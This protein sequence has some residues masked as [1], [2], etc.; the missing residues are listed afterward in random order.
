MRR[1]ASDRAA[2]R[3]ARARTSANSRVRLRPSRSRS[4]GVS[5]RP[6]VFCRSASACWNSTSL[7]SKPR[8]IH[9]YSSCMAPDVA[10]LR[11]RL[12]NSLRF[13]PGPIA[14][15]V[16]AHSQDAE[17][18]AGGLYR[19]EPSAWAA[20]PD[21]QKAVSNR[22]GWM[23][24]PQMVATEVPRLRA[25]ADAVKRDG[26]TD[27][28][29]LGMGG[30][31]LAPEVL[32][33][34][35]GVAAGWP[36]FHMLDSTDPA[37]V[38]AVATPPATSLYVLA[39]KSGTTIEP[40]ALAAHF[41]QTLVAAGVAEW[42]RHFVAITDPGTE[43]ER[44]A[45]ADGF[46]DVF[47]NPPDIG[48]RYSALSF[49][50]MVPAA[51]MGQDVE[52]IVHWGLAMLAAA[53]PGYGEAAGNPAVALGLALG[54]GAKA[55]RDKMTLVAPPQFEP[56][57]LWVEQLIAESTGKHG[58]G[59]VPIAGESIAQADSYDHDRL[60]VRLRSGRSTT[61]DLTATGAPVVEIDVGEPAALG[62]E[63]V[64]WEIATAVAGALLR[65]NPFDEPNVQ[66]AK[67]ATRRLLEA[68][69]KDRRLPAPPADATLP[70]GTVLTL[71]DAARQAAV[72]P[73]AL[74]KTL[75]SGDYFA[76]LAYV[77]SE[78]EAL[79]RELQALRRAIRDRAHAATMF[80]YGPR[81]LHST[82]QLHKGGPNTGV[83][84]VI[85]AR[86]GATMR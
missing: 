73:E 20:D 18:A 51:L 48:G 53:Q 65:I 3:S 16:A 35:I 24:S 34:I 28:V 57:G 32:R 42:A 86:R 40:N 47:L 52:A 21:V 13:A 22:L 11:G 6:S 79:A 44:R 75:R 39:S 54:A 38:R 4:S 26:F 63:F 77:S 46:R 81:Y 30:S 17:R 67:D 14:Q 25:F 33:A 49:F 56:F 1:W 69:K 12:Q 83:F 59:V 82:G 15:V 70:G 19:R 78:D 45:N 62:A 36:R 85:A 50:G 9:R 8:A 58:T 61:T 43:L 64:R 74:L 5:A 80:G 72:T 27:V 31:S 55:G 66:Q 68:Y 37:A 60:F 23:A 76:L 41:R 84:M 10:V 29:L 2:A 7:L 71:S